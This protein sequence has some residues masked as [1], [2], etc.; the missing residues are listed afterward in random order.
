VFPV[1]CFLNR[2]GNA[3]STSAAIVHGG[4][5]R[6]TFAIVISRGD[7]NQFFVGKLSHI[8]EVI[9]IASEELRRLATGT[10]DFGR[11]R[12]TA[13]AT[14]RTLSR[15][16]ASR[17]TTQR[18]VQKRIE[19]LSQGASIVLAITSQQTSAN[20]RVDLCLAQLDRE[21]MQPIATTL[22]MTAHALCGWA[23]RRRGA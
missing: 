8:S 20:Q 4:D 1:S 10:I 3:S 22:T 18:I 9:G 7:S 23:Q 2:L 17:R 12:N 14:W 21:T 15:C 16:C 6:F 13:W 19:R 11:P 5:R